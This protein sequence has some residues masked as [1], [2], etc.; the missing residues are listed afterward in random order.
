MVW[1]TKNSENNEMK[2]L[3]KLC[4]EMLEVAETLINNENEQIERLEKEIKDIKNKIILSEDNAHRGGR[5]SLTEDEINW[6]REL[7]A[8]GYSQR[9]TAESV[10]VSVG[11]VNKYDNKEVFK[12]NK[13]EQ[14]GELQ[15]SRIFSNDKKFETKEGEATFV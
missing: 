12:N 6:I 10:G 3:M 4:K 11:S 8:K 7:R 9:K 1:R 14:I 2:R 13:N 5:P 15:P